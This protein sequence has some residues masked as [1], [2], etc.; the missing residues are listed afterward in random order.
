M[1]LPFN[2]TRVAPVLL[3]F[4]DVASAIVVAFSLKGFDFFK[5]HR[6]GFLIGMPV[7]ERLISLLAQH[8]LTAGSGCSP[9]QWW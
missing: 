5:E 4:A 2:L 6:Y 8:V 3:K 9:Q 7:Y 1:N